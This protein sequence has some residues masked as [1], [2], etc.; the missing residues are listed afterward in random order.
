MEIQEVPQIV[1]VKVGSQ[2][3]IQQ[4]ILL[5]QRVISSRQML[6]QSKK[7]LIG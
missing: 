6:K 4:P 5:I 3:Q 1:A 7:S 2:R